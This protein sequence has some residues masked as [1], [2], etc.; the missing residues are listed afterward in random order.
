MLCLENGRARLI[1]AGTLRSR[2]SDPLPKRLDELGG[3]LDQILE[4]FSPDVMG[5][6]DIFSHYA[7]PSA[8]IVMA[9]ARGVYCYLAARRGIR[10]IALPSTMVKKLVTGNGRAPK[11]QVAGMVKHLLGLREMPGPS[12]LSD[13][14]AVALAA[15]ESDRGVACSSGSKA[16]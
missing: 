16:R 7:H 14:L 9:H 5:M 12:D 11:E 1:E 6:E 3:G 10:V 2:S 13:A 8:A 15:I 4:S